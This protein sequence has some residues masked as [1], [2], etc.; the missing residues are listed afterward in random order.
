MSSEEKLALAAIAI[1]VVLKKT[2]SERM[3]KKWLLM[4]PKQSDTTL[5]EE[6]RLYPDDF[7]NYLRMDYDIY[8]ELL[9]VISPLIVKQDTHFRDAITPHERLA[10]TLGYLAT[11]RSFED[12]KFFTRISAQSLG[13]IIP[14]TCRA[15]YETLATIPQAAEWIE[16]SNMFETKLQFPHSLGAVDGKHVT[17]SPPPDSGSYFYNYKGFHNLVL[18]AIANEN[19]EFI[20]VHFGT[21]GRVSDNGVIACTSFYKMLKQGNL[22]LQEHT[23]EG[24][25][26]VFVG[27]EAFALRLDFLKPFYSRL[28]NDQRRIF[29]YRLSRARRVVENTFGILVARFGVLKSRIC[30]SPEKIDDVVMACCVL[31][32]FLRVK[33]YQ[34]Y[35]PQGSLDVEDPETH[36][37]ET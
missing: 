9:E 11:G 29:N 2:K 26:F 13:H 24:F 25:P 37:L 19:Y 15:I 36:I 4:R 1:S 5:L 21:N 20:Y 3:G 32:N 28:L 34:Q 17:I 30:L 33:T 18:M 31:H 14:G 8:N 27:D 7:Q 22:N 23:P 35:T 10:A 16:I 12:L 6:L